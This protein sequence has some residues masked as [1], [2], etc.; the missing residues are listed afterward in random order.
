MYFS[1]HM[2]MF[3]NYVEG[4]EE[5]NSRLVRIYLLLNRCSLI[6]TPI[7]LVHKAFLSHL[8]IIGIISLMLQHFLFLYT[9][10]NIFNKFCRKDQSHKLINYPCHNYL[11]INLLYA[12]HILF[13]SLVHLLTS[14]KQYNMLIVL[15]WNIYLPYL[16]QQHYCKKFIQD[17]ERL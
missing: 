17:L 14:I 15:N 16:P 3:V 6:L 9:F 4:T 11:L 7:N 1:D 8:M 5:E 12:L 2:M 13:F 10:H